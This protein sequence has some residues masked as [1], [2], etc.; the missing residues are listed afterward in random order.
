MLNWFENHNPI[1]NQCFEK[2]ENRVAMA[3][4]VTVHYTDFKI[5]SHLAL[6][7]LF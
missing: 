6:L 5:H 3:I 4:A 1:E 7:T 2:G